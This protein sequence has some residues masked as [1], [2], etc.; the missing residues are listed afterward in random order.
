MRLTA[1]AAALTVAVYDIR[2]ITEH[3]FELEKRIDGKR[4]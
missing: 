2:I 1:L 4:C 3:G